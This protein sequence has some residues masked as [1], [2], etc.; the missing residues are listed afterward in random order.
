MLIGSDT[1][2][3]QG[4]IFALHSKS[5]HSTTEHKIE[6][7]SVRD[8]E[9]MDAFCFRCISSTMPVFKFEH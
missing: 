7:I 1:N 8:L 9:H 6:C 4:T 2:L 3:I 5:K